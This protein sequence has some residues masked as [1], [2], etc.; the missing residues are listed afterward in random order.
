[1]ATLGHCVPGGHRV[2]LTTTPPVLYEPE[3]QG[4]SKLEANSG[5]WY[6]AAASRQVVASLSSD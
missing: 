1:M 4:I 3:L 6:P 5:T 2:Q